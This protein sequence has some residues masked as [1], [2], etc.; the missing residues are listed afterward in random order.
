MPVTWQPMRRT[1]LPHVGHSDHKGA[2]LPIV[3]GYHRMLAETDGLRPLL[4]P[5]NLFARKVPVM[6]IS[7]MVVSTSWAQEAQWPVGTSS[8]M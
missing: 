4:G 6:K 1:A 2:G 8:L 7:R 3:G 5:G